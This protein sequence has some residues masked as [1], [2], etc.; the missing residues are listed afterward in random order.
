MADY[1]LEHC[2]YIVGIGEG[3]II[4]DTIQFDT[5][6]LDVPF[7]GIGMLQW[8][9][10]RSF[11]LLRDIFV[12]D[13]KKWTITPPTGIKQAIENNQRW[14][15]HKWY[16]GTPDYNWVRKYL[17]TETGQK[18]QLDKYKKECEGYIKVL[19]GTGVTNKKCQ[20]Y[21]SDV[22]NQYGEG[23]VT[24]SNAYTGSAL[25]DL[26]AM[27][28]TT[29]QAYPNRRSYC[30]NYLMKADFS[31]KSPV[32]FGVI[33][34]NTPPTEENQGG[35]Q[36]TK[37]ETPSVVDL[38]GID[39]F[40]KDFTK[41]LEKLL[42]DMIKKNMYEYNNVNV[43]S[44][45]YVKATKIS[46]TMYHLGLNTSFT[47]GLEDAF[48]KGMDGLGSLLD[49]TDNQGNK[50]SEGGNEGSGGNESP[51]KP[52]PPV[53]PKGE[54]GLKHLESLLGQW[55]GNG[56]CYG[57]SAEY[58]GF[59]DGAGMGA[60]TKYGFS[61]VIGNTMNASDIGSAYDWGKLG[62]KVIKNPR[63]NQLVVGSI[64][65]WSNNGKVADWYADPQYGHTG[66][67]RGLSGNKIQTYEQNTE[68][69]MIVAKCDR[70]YYGESSIASIV[71]PPK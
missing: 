36:G 53:G 3:S 62:W 26:T 50:G 48:K 56:Q 30:Y 45:K 14:N 33:K 27:H 7:E 5:I 58:S 63:Y 10:G 37:P 69:G 60:G 49:T 19:A 44:N 65:N 20:V 70:G 22:C 31:K 46:N 11:D 25:T 51:E 6:E 24:G 17:K 4:N 47:K 38:S 41:D 13:G 57:L 18:I 64:I 59:M 54:K 2:M 68:Y 1:Q 29:D 67:I 21:G 32:D 66:V 71:I 55:V 16:K 28:N 39:K 8:T 40:F 12:A 35:E 9:W 43:L 42:N 23:G 52:K 61:H 34:P 15:S